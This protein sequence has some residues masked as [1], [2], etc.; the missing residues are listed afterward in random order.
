MQ[1]LLASRQRPFLDR[2]CPRCSHPL[3]RGGRSVDFPGWPEWA[4]AG[5]TACELDQTPGLEAVRGE[6]AGR[7]GQYKATAEFHDATA[8]G[9]AGMKAVVGSSWV[10]GLSEAAHW[11]PE[12]A[13]TTGRVGMVDTLIAAETSLVAIEE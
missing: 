2:P 3:S 8:A 5:S 12:M 6:G 7:I 10:E 11:H 9:W 1:I 13:S 4:G